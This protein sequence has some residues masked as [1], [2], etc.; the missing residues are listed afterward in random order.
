M[1]FGTPLDS[2]DGCLVEVGPEAGIVLAAGVSDSRVPG[3][4]FFSGRVALRYGFAFTFERDYLIP[5][6]VYDDFQRE[7]VGGEAIEFLI[8]RGDAFPRADVVGLRVSTGRDDTV[9]AK[10][11][12]LAMGLLAFADA[13]PGANTPL[14]PL[15]ASVWVDPDAQEIYRLSDVDDW[16]PKLLRLAVPCFLISPDRLAELPGVLAALPRAQFP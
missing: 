11:L 13:N 10:A 1:G 14:V 9:F 8:T 2:V 15:R 6:L 7:H 3:Q 16:A 5:E 12:D 4:R